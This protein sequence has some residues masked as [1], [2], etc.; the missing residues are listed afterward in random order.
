MFLKLRL[1][2]DIT[3]IVTLAVF[4]LSAFTRF[5][6]SIQNS[7]LGLSGEGAVINIMSI[8]LVWISLYYFTFEMKQI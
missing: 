3:G 8:Q 5:I 4:W 2:I 6:G 1:R 7:S